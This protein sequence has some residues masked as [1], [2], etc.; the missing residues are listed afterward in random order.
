MKIEPHWGYLLLRAY[1][2]SLSTS[3]GAWRIFS[4]TNLTRALLSWMTSFSFSKRKLFAN[5]VPAKRAPRCGL[6]IPYFSDSFFYQPNL[7]PDLTWARTR[8]YGH[9]GP[10]VPVPIWRLN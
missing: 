3:Q 7:L 5:A 9:P 8:T 2:V 4:D 6:G 10:M 1:E